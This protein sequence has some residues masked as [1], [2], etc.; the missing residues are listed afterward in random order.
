MFQFFGFGLDPVRE[1]IEN[2][3]GVSATVVPLDDTSPTYKFCFQHP[4]QSSITALQRERAAAAA[5]NALDNSSGCAR[6]EG[7]IAVDKSGGSGRIT[8]ALVRRAHEVDG[9]TDPKGTVSSKSRNPEKTE[10]SKKE[11]ANNQRKYAEMKSIPLANRLEAKRSHIHGWGLFTKV[12][13][14]KHSMI[15]EYMGEVVRQSIADIREKEYEESQV[16][17]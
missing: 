16:G 13:F 4:E 14:P 7:I 11:T 5:E 12:K 10:E 15:I 1:A 3:P 8:R 9:S 17:R 2:F 6:V